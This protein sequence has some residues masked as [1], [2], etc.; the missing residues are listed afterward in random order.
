MISINLPNIPVRILE[1]Q[2]QQHHECSELQVISLQFS[3]VIWKEKGFLVLEAPNIR[4]RFILISGINEVCASHSCAQH[5]LDVTGL[6]YKYVWHL[7]RKFD[8]TGHHEKNRRN[9]ASQ[10]YTWTHPHKHCCIPWSFTASRNNKWAILQN[11][12]WRSFQGLCFAIKCNN[13]I[14]IQHLSWKDKSFQIK[15]HRF[16]F[17]KQLIREC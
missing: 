8:K 15:C 13:W 16:F 6:A 17:Q 1:N 4:L 3:Q 10:T 12:P 14:L 2:H 7:S 11:F 5:Q 9:L